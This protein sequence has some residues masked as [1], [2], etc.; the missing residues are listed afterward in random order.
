MACLPVS[1]N[2]VALDCGNVGGIRTLYIADTLNVDAVTVVDG[3]VTAVTMKE[4]Q[5]FKKFEFRKGNAN[6]VSSGSRD[7]QAGTSYVE[8]VTTASFNHMETAKRKEMQGLATANTYVIAKDENGK[9]WFIG[10]GSYNAGSVSGNTGSAMGDANNY[11]AVLT[12]MTSE[13]PMEVADSV[14]TTI[15]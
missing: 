6:F 14:L 8:T 10:Y 3:E 4:T 7:D 5:K 2:G 11:E 15:V 13:L 9:N 12:S 1:F